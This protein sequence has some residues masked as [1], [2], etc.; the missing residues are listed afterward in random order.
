MSFMPIF[1]NHSIFVPGLF[2]EYKNNFHVLPV[3]RAGFENVSVKNGLSRLQNIT[4]K[5][6]ASG[7]IEPEL[8]W[9]LAP[10]ET[11]EF[12]HGWICEQIQRRP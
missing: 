6:E 8:N 12:K 10:L 2:S 11:F 1:R 5:G 4:R 9:H 7:K 3:L